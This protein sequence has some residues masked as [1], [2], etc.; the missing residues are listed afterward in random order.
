MTKFHLSASVVSICLVLPLL[1]GATASA[2]PGDGP[3]KLTVEVSWPE[4]NL[5]VDLY[6][7]EPNQA[8]PCYYRN[9]DTRNGGR[10]VD[11][12]RGGGNPERYTIDGGPS[13]IYQVRLKM[14]T[15]RGSTDSVTIRIYSNGRL[16]DEFANRHLE[17]GAADDDGLFIGN[18][19]VD[20]QGGVRR[21]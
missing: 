18:Y 9:K 6:V 11:V 8:E 7:Y 20:Q 1:S 15:R 13:G 14:F 5:D 21:R 2:E 17:S 12:T 16:I 10:L 19:E 3:A 4:R